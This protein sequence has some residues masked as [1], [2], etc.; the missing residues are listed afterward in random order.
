MIKVMMVVPNQG[1][2]TSFYRAVGPFAAMSRKRELN[3]NFGSSIDWA[4]LDLIDVMFLQRPYTDEHKK[5]AKMCKLW[6]VPLWVDYDDLLFD[7]PTDNPSHAHFSKPEIKQNIVEIIRD[8]TVVTVSTKQLKDCI[9]VPKA[10]LNQNVHVIPNALNEKLLHLQRPFT[11]KKH[12]NWRGTA[13]HMRDVIA[14]GHPIIEYA[15]KHPDTTFTFV[16]FDPWIVT[17]AMPPKNTVV[18]P[19][20]SMGEFFGF[21]SATN[22]AVQM[23]P[24]SPSM[25]NL[26]KSNIA[27]I[28]GALAGAVCV[29]PDW[30]EWRRPGIF[31]YKDETTY[32]AALEKA[33]SDSEAAKAAHEESM[34]FIRSH[35]MLD[36]VN[37]ARFNILDSLYAIAKGSTGVPFPP[38]GEPNH[39]DEVMELE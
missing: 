28:E 39:G 25:F 33:L 4:T 17:E 22:P 37:V 11:P 7:V 23:V 3:L 19:G 9:Q 13:T 18:V 35:L 29:G 20:L 32:Y 16:G 24:L 8:A 10:P 26:C 27:W 15:Q 12:V 14:Y 38:G 1:D 30:A 31:N 34:D 36:Q 2:A 21:M 5:L 6:Q